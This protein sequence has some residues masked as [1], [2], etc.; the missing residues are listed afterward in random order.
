MRFILFETES[1]TRDTKM[2][3]KFSGKRDEK[4]LGC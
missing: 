2:L 3:P 1:E 4:M